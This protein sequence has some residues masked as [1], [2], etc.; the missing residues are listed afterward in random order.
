MTH[1]VDEETPLLH[2]KQV[3]KS[4]TPLPWFQFSIVLFLQLSEPLTFHVISP[5][6]P[7]L[8]L[9]LGIT[10]GDEK[11]VGYY[12]GLMHTIF[13][14]T[15]ACTVLHWS[16]ASDRIGRKP[17]IMLGLFGLSLSMYC[18][19]LST[20]FMGL[21]LSRSLCGAL[22]GNIGVMKSMLAEL[23]DET[24]LSRAYAYTPISWCLGMVLGPMIGGE[25]SRPSERFP[26]WFGNNEFLKKYPYF[27]PCAIP[28]TFTAIACLVTFVF[29]K[30][31]IKHPIPISQWL[32]LG[33][34][35]KQNSK[36]QASLT[37][38]EIPDDE[39]PLPLRSLLTPK[40]ITSSAN[41]ASLALV[42]IAFRTVQP[43][44]FATRI[45]DGGLGL[46]PAAIGDILAVF[47]LLNGLLQLAILAPLLERW[48]SKK[49]FILGVASAIPLFSS[50]PVI[51]YLARTQGYSTAVWIAVLFQISCSTLISM[52][53]GAIF[54]F[55]Q[56]AAPNRA[57][58]GATNGLNQMT[59]SVMRAIGP[60][61]ANSLYSLSIDKGY[62]GG[63]MVYYVLSGTVLVSLYLATLLSR[64]HRS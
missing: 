25:L 1:Q 22:N 35:D 37:T 14:L 51:N 43:V 44:F 11:K 4:P 63:Q 57:S 33:K 36:H 26:R 6:A 18:F 17:V 54:M 59:V 45:E 9:N 3:K 38:R 49:V 29:L 12:V 52:S 16:R 21:L 61:A 47:G 40:V 58:L 7:E 15:E 8:I 39:R 19:G 31:T 62:M 60:G 46:S 48:G 10:N 53:Y 50:F 2:S 41:S 55:I 34:E 30:E 56:T 13:F 42:D 28:A 27:L 24:N 64:D 32:G 23:T 20:T 5:F